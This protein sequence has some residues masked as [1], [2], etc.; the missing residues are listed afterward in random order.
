MNIS[1]SSKEKLQDGGQSA[2]VCMQMSAFAPEMSRLKVTEKVLVRDGKRLIRQDLKATQVGAE[3][4]KEAEAKEV[5]RSGLATSALL[6][7]IAWKL[8]MEV[9]KCLFCIMFTNNRDLAPRCIA[10]LLHLMNTATLHLVAAAVVALHCCFCIYGC[11]TKMHQAR[12]AAVVLEVCLR[13][14]RW[15]ASSLFG[16]KSAAGLSMK[17][18]A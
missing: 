2:C 5:K 11:S 9:C 18:P 14:S 6:V 13:V 10:L 3:P 4:P 7:F 12:L 15:S 17:S 16:S 1:P 8:N